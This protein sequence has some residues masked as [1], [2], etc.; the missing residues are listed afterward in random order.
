MYFPDYVEY[1][2]FHLEQNNYKS[3]L[4]GGGVR[5]LFNLKN[6]H[7]YDIATSA[8]PEQV[9]QLFKHVIST[10][11]K[12]G[13][14]TVIINGNHVEVTTLRVD[15]KYNDFRHP[16]KI[17][18]TNNLKEDLSRRDLTI[19]A[20]AV[21]LDG[22]V[23]DYFNGLNDIEN[24]IIR[25]VGNPDERYYEDPLRCMRAIRFS[26][27]FDFDIE[28]ETEKSIIKNSKLI[29]KISKERIRDELCKILMSDY[30]GYGIEMLQKCNLLQYI[31]PELC[32]C[33][34]FDQHNIHH[35]KNVFD[36]IIS[37]LN[38]TP[39]ILN[40]RLAALL[41]DIGKP[42]CFT[43]DENKQGHFYGHHIDGAEMTEEIMK[44]LKFDNKTITNVCILV[45]DHMS[46]YD[47]L[48]ASSVKKFI[49]RVGIE[50]LND[51]FELQVADVKGSAPPH[52]YSNVLKLKE[53]VYRIL[54]EKQPLTV[55]D[56]AIN[57]FDLISIGVKPGKE[58]GGL[59]NKLLESVLE[60]PDINTKEEL[61][62]LVNK[63]GLN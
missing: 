41:H 55:K 34:N 28:E 33:I 13:T 25:A 7:D 10:G 31:I 54:N 42:K 22:N 37:V 49:N 27:V 35:D 14:V 38:H 60:N 61:L 23:Y 62:N 17:F 51:L 8:T 3:Y 15:G 21:D 39:N 50:N 24:K 52:D 19:N 12:H 29:T 4:V 16:D 47:F 40:V 44:R 20:I 18:F 58:M 2:M 26:A 56:L 6:I 36:H 48:R 9:K 11:E 43:I 5:D 59:L 45:R 53:D 1:I 32:E 57:G 63:E 30:P 46:R